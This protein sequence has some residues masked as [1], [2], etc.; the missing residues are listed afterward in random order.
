MRCGELCRAPAKMGT[1]A[2]DYC[3]RCPD[4]PDGMTY[5]AANALRDWPGGGAEPW[6]LRD[7]PR[8]QEPRLY[9][10]TLVGLVKRRWAR[11]VMLGPGR[12]G[13][14]LTAAGLAARAL[15]VEL[16]P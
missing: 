11:R 15:V 16:E 2:R 1:G 9:R 10:T 4:L 14:V 7:G 3:E 13:G 5:G 12:P 6:A 8:T